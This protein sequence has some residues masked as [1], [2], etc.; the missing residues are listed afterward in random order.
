MQSPYW[1]LSF[2]LMCDTSDF[3]VNTVLGQRRNNKYFVIYY[4]RKTLDS[5]QILQYRFYWRHIENTY[6]FC[7]TC[8]N[9]KKLGSMTKR[10]M[11]Y[12]NLILKIEIFDHWKIDFMVFFII[13]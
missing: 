12:L 4:A 5:T 10:K 7:K 1:C 13:I 11:I 6:D 2:E 9:C 8:E 3:V